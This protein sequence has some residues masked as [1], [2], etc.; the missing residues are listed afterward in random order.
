MISTKRIS[1]ILLRANW[2]KCSTAFK[3]KAS[4][5]ALPASRIHQ[6][7][8]DIVPEP[9][10]SAKSARSGSGRSKEAAMF[11]RLSLFGV[12]SVSMAPVARSRLGRPG[13]RPAIE[14]TW[15]APGALCPEFG[16]NDAGL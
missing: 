16:N 14:H 2:R 8:G 12:L 11:R 6:S 1:G 7:L 4:L 9:T 3:T 13:R 5:I 15:S 10:S